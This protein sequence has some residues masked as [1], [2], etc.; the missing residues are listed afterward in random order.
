MVSLNPMKSFYNKVLGFK[1]ENDLKNSGVRFEICMRDVMYNYSNEYEKKYLVRL[2]N[3]LSH[4]KI[5]VMG[6]YMKF[7]Q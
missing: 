2:L 6:T 4:V 3:W 5:Q 7:L 1:I